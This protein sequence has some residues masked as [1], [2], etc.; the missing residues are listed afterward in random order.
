[1]ALFGEPSP[2]HPRDQPG[3]PCQHRF[4]TSHLG[5]TRSSEQLVR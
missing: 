4:P 1:V 2:H 3:H 5:E